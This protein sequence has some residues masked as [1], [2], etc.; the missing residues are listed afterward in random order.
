MEEKKVRAHAVIRGR[1]QGVFFRAET[2]RT[3]QGLGV[4]GWVKNRFDGTV[5]AIMEGEE[6][7][8][9]AALAWCQRGPRL[10]RVE[11][12]DVVWEPYLGEFDTF[13]IHH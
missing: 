6:S 3:A 1:V 7:G 12:V 2:Q 4:S 8:V 5:E 9:T 10:A 13:S 11:K